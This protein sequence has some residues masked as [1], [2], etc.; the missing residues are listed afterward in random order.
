MNK[1]TYFPTL[2]ILAASAVLIAIS[3]SALAQQDSGSAGDF[4]W[5]GYWWPFAEGGI[6]GP[7]AK[8]DQVY[9][10]QA[11][12]F[13]QSKGRVPRDNVQEWEGFCHAWS[14]A[15]VSEKEPRTAKT[16]KGIEFSPGEQKALLCGL[17]YSDTANT[18][19]DRYGDGLG[20]E[21]KNDLT[22]EQVRLNLQNYV[23]QQEGP[24][25]FDLDGGDQVWNYPVYQYEVSYTDAG[26]GMVNGEMTLV[27]AD[28]G[29]DIEY[30]GTEPLIYTYTFTC[31]MAGG[32]VVAG[33]GRWTGD[34]IDDHPDF[35][36]YPYVA[37][38]D[39]PHIQVAQVSDILDNPVGNSNADSDDPEQPNNLDEPPANDGPIGDL[40]P[41]PEVNTDIPPGVPQID[42]D[43]ILS[44]VEMVSLISN[45][46]SHF[47]LDIFVD[48]N[49]GGRY[50]QGDP[51]RVSAK[52]DR[53]GYLYIFDIGPAGDIELVFPRPGEPHVIPA[54]TLVDLPASGVQPW[55]VAQR[56]GE[57]HMRGLVTTTPLALSGFQTKAGDKGK[58][59]KRRHVQKLH[60]PPSASKRL[61]NSIR[62]YYSKNAEL[63]PPEKVKAFAQD[64]CLFFVIG[65]EGG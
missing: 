14:A 63:K 29:V 19:G 40:P 10:T 17:H 28:D 32:S 43:Q 46:T 62:G 44:P 3:N 7:L 37:R 35:A 34:S 42:F 36:W 55:C 57:H 45:K 6:T 59:K 15:S 60:L 1:R 13:E 54:G 50:R 5:S 48:A 33:S 64:D 25:I 26:G 52:S 27:A 41:S 8:Y 65:K 21:D 56:P 58:G 11:V 49:D 53:E 61:T 38:A 51:I 23:K 22:P 30:Q 16:F 18:Y 39:N 31:R 4:P 2:M 24:L 9:G 12:A 20:S 47:G